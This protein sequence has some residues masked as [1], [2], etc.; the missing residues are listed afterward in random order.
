MSDM[1]RNPREKNE[2]DQRIIEAGLQRSESNH[3]DWS[4]DHSEHP[5]N[6][7][8]SRKIYDTTVIIF[9]E[10]YTTVVA[11]TGPSAASLARKEYDISR[12]VALTAFAFM[13]NAGQAL[14]G[15]LIPPF[16]ESFGRKPP[17][18]YSCAVF[19]IGNL[20]SGVVPHPAGVF[21]GRFM[22]GF[23][24]AVPS[25]ITAG[26]V[27]DMYAGRSRVWLI[28]FWNTFT[29]IGIILGPIYGSY[30]SHV[31]GW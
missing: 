20:L 16:S 24:S 1:S 2:D 3:V 27:E 9:F 7:P 21:I 31:I 15:L 28:F 4:K 13:Y 12:V 25:V 5:R 26:S 23:A 11:T 30:I 29:T 6:W 10:F 8:L 17:Y 22:A 14:G 18:I 19:S